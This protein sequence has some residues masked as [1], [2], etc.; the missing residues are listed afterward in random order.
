[1]NMHAMSTEDLVT[2]AGNEVEKYWILSNNLTLLESLRDTNRKDLDQA[3]VCLEIWKAILSRPTEEQ[4]KIRAL[5][6]DPRPGVRLEAA[7]MLENIAFS[8]AL[9]VWR[10]LAQRE[11]TP[12]GDADVY[13]AH[14]RI[15]V[16][17]LAEEGRIPSI[18]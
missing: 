12:E 5:L 9:P 10:E 11:L 14:A 6:S 4:L 13:G 3:K 8:D 18:F 17:R 15:A 16:E 1:M 7:N 2:L